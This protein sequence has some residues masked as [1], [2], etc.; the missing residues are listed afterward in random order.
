MPHS[1]DDH[2]KMAQDAKEEKPNCD[3]DLALTLTLTQTLTTPEDPPLMTP[4]LAPF[5]PPPA[6]G[7][8]EA[9][10]EQE[11]EERTR[12]LVRGCK[13]KYRQ[14]TMARRLVPLFVQDFTPAGRLAN[15]SPDPRGRRG[16]LVGVGGLI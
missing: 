3:P 11:L 16:T 2:H 14:F 10:E 8:E 6:L 12:E 15:Q 9:R 7:P 13:A 1:C 4:G 5:P